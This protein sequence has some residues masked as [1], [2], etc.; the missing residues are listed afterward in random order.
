MKTSGIKKMKKDKLITDL[1]IKIGLVIMLVSLNIG[2]VDSLNDPY[3]GAIINEKPEVD[4]GDIIDPPSELNLGKFSEGDVYGLWWN[5]NSDNEDGFN[6]Y[7]NGALIQTLGPD[8][9][10][11]TVSIPVAPGTPMEYGVEAYNT[12]GTSARKTASVTCP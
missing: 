5:D 11:A 10:Q 2:C 8:T 7:Q 4:P 6:V 1:F 12:A 9:T 3:P